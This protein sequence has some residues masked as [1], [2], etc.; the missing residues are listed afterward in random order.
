MKKLR[1]DGE[2]IEPGKMYS[3]SR[4]ISLLNVS[5][6]NGYNK[7]K[8]EISSD[9]QEKYKEGYNCGYSAGYN[10]ASEDL[11]ELKTLLSK[12]LNGDKKW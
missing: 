4:V 10:E 3:G 9:A 6:S 1:V 5:Y 2:T 8:S 11:A 7:A 12:I